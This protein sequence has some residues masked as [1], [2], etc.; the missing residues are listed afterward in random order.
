MGNVT[1]D[2]AGASRSP[3]E[4]IEWLRL[5]CEDTNDSALPRVA[6]IGDSITEGYFRAVQ[7][8]LVG[9]ARV[10]YLA[11][12][13]S[14]ASKAYK[15]MVK[16]FVADSDY[17]VVHYNY[18]LH[19]YGVDDESYERCCKEMLEYIKKYAKTVVGLS[20]TV[21]TPDLKTESAEWKEKVSARNARL[22]KLAQ[23]LSLPIDDLCS[24]S[25]DL[26]GDDR[27][28]DGVH[29]SET[30]YAALAACVVE[31]LEKVL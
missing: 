26:S 19:A 18:G 27:A 20:T 30:G 28:A 2:T 22:E 9:R 17:D 1:F 5:W 31:S 14:V 25:K 16:A 13:Y 6:L 24:V 11:T 4:N 15:E 23:K 8:A 12:S 3:K 29:F 7:K 10:D 21:L